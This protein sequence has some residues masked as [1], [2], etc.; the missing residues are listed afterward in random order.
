VHI[1]IVVVV[2]DIIIT[3][4][5][6]MI[7]AYF[8]GFRAFRILDFWGVGFLGFRGSHRVGWDWLAP[9]LLLRC[10]L[11]ASGSSSS[12]SSSKSSSFPPMDVL[13]GRT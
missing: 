3:L 5:I 6:I 12:M 11:D 4:I 7:L 1:G 8:L 13:G 9:P 10:F 2:V